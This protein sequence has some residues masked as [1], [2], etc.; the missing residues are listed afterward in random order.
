MRQAKAIT[1]NDQC[2]SRFYRLETLESLQNEEQKNKKDAKVSL[3][4]AFY[5]TVDT[6]SACVTLIQVVPAW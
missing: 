6:M 1:T 4:L 2:A 3:A 5:L